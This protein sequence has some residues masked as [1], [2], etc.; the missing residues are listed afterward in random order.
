MRIKSQQY[1]TCGIWLFKTVSNM[2]MLPRSHQGIDYKWI[3]E[4]LLEPIKR[5]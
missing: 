1:R 2:H 3:K 4:E 5:K